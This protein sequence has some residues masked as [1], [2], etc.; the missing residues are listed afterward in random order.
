M[1]KDGKKCKE[2]A[3]ELKMNEKTIYSNSGWRQA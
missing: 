1:A 3:V 2:I